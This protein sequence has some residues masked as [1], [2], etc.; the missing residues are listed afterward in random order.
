MFMPSFLIIVLVVLLAYGGGV[1]FLVCK[2]AKSRGKVARLL[3]VL[4]LAV[5]FSPIAWDCGKFFVFK[6]RAD[7]LI[8]DIQ[9][10]F[11]EDNLD[12]YLAANEDR[13]GIS[14]WRL[15]SPEYNKYVVHFSNSKSWTAVLTMHR[16]AIITTDVS[17]REVVRV[18]WSA[19]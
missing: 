7:A 19:L 11:E 5:L 9:D 4:G 3:C 1:T 18:A 13:F 12:E 10:G 17:H 6:Q 2:F 16:Y 8:A 15:F 14:D